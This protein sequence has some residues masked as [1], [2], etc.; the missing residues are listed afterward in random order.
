MSI[1][2]FG[3]IAAVLILG[4]TTSAGEP[5]REPDNFRGMRWG[6]TIEELK[7]QFP[8][9]PFGNANHK[10]K[11]ITTYHSLGQYI[12]TIRADIVYGFL[13]NKFSQATIF[14][15][16]SDFSTIGSSFT[17]RYGSPHSRRK[18]GMGTAMG[19]KVNNEIYE[20]KGQTMEI[21]LAKFA[22]RATD[23]LAILGKRE[24]TEEERRVQA[25]KGKDSAK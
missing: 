4:A 3:A 9:I 14:F 15:K 11:R 12:G 18:I 2:I 16:S 1:R 24:F 8:N 20:W 6:S 19:A 25:Q 13:D 5:W 22:G 17:A 23:G 7:T 21:T 10:G